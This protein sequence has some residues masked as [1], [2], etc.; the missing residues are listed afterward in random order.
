MTRFLVLL[1]LTLKHSLRSIFRLQPEFP[2]GRRERIYVDASFIPSHDPE[3]P[4]LCG[5]GIWLPKRNLAIALQTEAANSME[6]ETL[7]LLAGALTARSFHISRPVLFSDCKSAVLVGN[8]HLQLGKARNLKSKIKRMVDLSSAHHAYPS[9]FD[10]LQS[11]GGCLEWRPREDNR[12]ADLASNIGSRAGH[13]GIVLG[14]SKNRNHTLN[15]VLSLVRDN[16]SEPKTRSADVIHRRFRCGTRTVWLASQRPAKSRRFLR[17][18]R[19]L[20]AELSA[21]VA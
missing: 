19:S 14:G 13:M 9:I 4:N 20:I 10:A 5:I 3:V 6:S 16:D 7:A 15:D 21:E 11:L 18:A 8:R 12:E 2:K 1:A 17:Q